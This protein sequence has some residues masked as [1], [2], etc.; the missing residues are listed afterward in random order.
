MKKKRGET[1]STNYVTIRP[2]QCHH[3]RI[4]ILFNFILLQIDTRFF[5]AYIY[6]VKWNYKYIQHDTINTANNIE[7]KIEL[8]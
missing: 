3:N 1:L 2:Y 4:I 6:G 7:K 8:K 5:S